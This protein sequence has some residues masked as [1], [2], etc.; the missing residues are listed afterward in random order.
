MVEGGN[1]GPGGDKEEGTASTY[2]A[3]GL[4]SDG[5]AG[6]N[7]AEGETGINDPDGDILGKL[8]IPRKLPTIVDIKRALPQHVFQAPVSTSM[9]YAVKDLVQVAGM[10]LLAEWVWSSSLL[11]TWALWLLLPVYWLIQGTFFTAMFVM[12][13][14]AGHSS[15]SSS[16]LLNDIV[17]TVFHT[18]L[19]CPYYC[20]KL[21]HRQ[22]HKNTGNM[23]KDEVYYPIRKKDDD[24]SKTLPGFGMGIGWYAYLV[25][26]YGPGSRRVHH[27]NANHPMF[28]QHFLACAV[29]IACVAGWAG[30]LYQY[31]AT[32]G[33]WKLFVHYVVP[34]FIFGSYTVIITF[35]H[36][37]EDD[38][39]WYDNSLWEYVRGQL[40]SV[41]RHYGWCHD[42]IHNIGTHQIHHLFTKV[43]H[44]HLEEATR[45]FREKFPE[46]VQT[47]EERILP[48]F[49]RMFAKYAAQGT[50]PDGAKVHV[51]K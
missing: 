34:D 15:F 45:V 8:P 48:A 3:V 26:G 5:P 28:A 27:F 6:V 20:W 24:G 10:F 1:P 38:V 37:T 14:D 18:F 2:D 30:V 16:D 42:I 31:A 22:H 19:L 44:Y 25:R 47:R 40:S 7:P 36:H 35:L 13:H 46:L 4:S 23:D 39:P 9:Y 32:F 41:D 17:G 51:Y 12:G 29:S 11:P 43:P 50:V 33:F 21:S 49:W